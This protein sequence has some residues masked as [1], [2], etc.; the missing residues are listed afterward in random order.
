MFSSRFSSA[1]AASVQF[2]GPML[3]QKALVDGAAWALVGSFVEIGG[4]RLIGPAGKIYAFASVES[5]GRWIEHTRA[6]GI[7]QI[8]I[9]DGMSLAVSEKW[10]AAKREKLAVVAG[11]LVEAAARQQS[12]AKRAALLAESDYCLTKWGV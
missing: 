11:R 2:I 7:R 6:A 5:A 12:S 1:F 9:V 4:K 10:K 3:A 8:T